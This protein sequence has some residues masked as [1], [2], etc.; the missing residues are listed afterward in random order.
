M[1]WPIRYWRPFSANHETR[2][3]GSLVVQRHLD[4][5]SGGDERQ[6]NEKKAGDA[7]EPPRFC[8]WDHISSPRSLQMPVR[9]VWRLILIDEDIGSGRM[10]S[11]GARWSR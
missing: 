11:A 6:P 8:S 5:H 1:E 3:S 7:A 2:A 9:V 10:Q 4:V